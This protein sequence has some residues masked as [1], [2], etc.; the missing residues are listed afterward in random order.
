[1]SIPY[2]QWADHRRTVLEKDGQ[3]LGGVVTTDVVEAPELQR[4]RDYD[5]PLQKAVWDT[6]ATLQ[7]MV[8]QRYVLLL[9]QLT[10]DSA[11]AFRG[12]AVNSCARGAR[13]GLVDRPVVDA[14]DSV[15]FTADKD[16]LCVTDAH[17]Y[18]DEDPSEQKGAS[19][20][21]RA[22]L[23]FQRARAAQA[24][25]VD[26]EQRPEEL[27]RFLTDRL[28]RIEDA[29]RDGVVLIALYDGDLA[30][31]VARELQRL[32]FRP[33]VVEAERLIE[34]VRSS[35]PRVVVL[36]NELVPLAQGFD[37]WLVSVGH[38]QLN[39]SNACYL[40]AIR[41]FYSTA[42]V[43]DVVREVE[44]AARGYHFGKAPAGLR[45]ILPDRST[46]LV[47]QP[48]RRELLLALSRQGGRPIDRETVLREV[49]PVEGA[50]ADLPNCLKQLVHALRKA[51]PRLSKYIIRTRGFLWLSSDV[52]VVCEPTE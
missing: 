16:S 38:R 52:E 18:R 31:S 47:L 11:A 39:R 12:Y 23:R 45:V 15:G 36:Q 4:A 33:E 43:A 25:Q 8:H 40:P 21:K 29:P 2:R 42:R 50:R 6:S 44:W 13:T 7:H 26:D 30:T 20:T 28:G 24:A 49:Y 10:R 3:G 17:E 22:R 46:I 41:V 19:V 35:L 9:G 5:R 1:M 48:L 34:T 32:G 37:G 51:E 27:D 14:V